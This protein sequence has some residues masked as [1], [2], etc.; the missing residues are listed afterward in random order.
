M[1]YQ[2]LFAFTF[3]LLVLAVPY[4]ILCFLINCVSVASKHGE[5]QGPLALIKP[6]GKNIHY[7]TTTM[8]VDRDLC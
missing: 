1:G 7:Y 6:R 8:I 3:C 4:I 2:F 5:I